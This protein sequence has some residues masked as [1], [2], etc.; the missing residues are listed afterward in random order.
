MKSKANQNI[1]EAAPG[2]PVPPSFDVRVPLPAD[3][4]GVPLFSQV[5]DNYVETQSWIG[6]PVASI[7]TLPLKGAALKGMGLP[8]GLQ[9]VWK[10]GSAAVSGGSAAATSVASSLVTRSFVAGAA[11]A[12]AASFVALQIGVAVG[13]V[14]SSPVTTWIDRRFDAQRESD[15][16]KV[17]PSCKK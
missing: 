14:F 7:A 2:A 16:Q 5:A 12:S 10:V 4:S 15:F 8:T 13:S 1:V 17:C 11:K 3:E 9:I 6:F